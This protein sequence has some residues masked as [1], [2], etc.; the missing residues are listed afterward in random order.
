[1]QFIDWVVLFMDNLFTAE[2]PWKFHRCGSGTRCSRLLLPVVVAVQ[3][4]RNCVVSQLPLYT[5]RQTAAW[6]D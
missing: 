4:C 2:H 5:S 3:T 1:M 6:L